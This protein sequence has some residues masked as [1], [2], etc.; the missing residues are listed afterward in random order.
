MKRDV[1]DLR[2]APE[3]TE[4]AIF[5]KCPNVRCLLTGP[6]RRG[7]LQET[8]EG[9]AVSDGPPRGSRK[10]HQGSRIGSR[11]EV[12]ANANICL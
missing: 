7:G 9:R 2:Q 12:T 11:T 3:G 5:R 8:L 10:Q 1:C 4:R 6:R